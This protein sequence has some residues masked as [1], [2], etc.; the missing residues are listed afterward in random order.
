MMPNQ[1]Q[2]LRP[3]NEK[4]RSGMVGGTDLEV[5]KALGDLGGKV[6]VK[7]IARKAGL[8]VPYP[9]L[10]CNSLGKHDYMNVAGSG[11]CK[12]TAKGYQALRAKGWRSK[13]EKQGGETKPARQLIGAERF[14]SGLRQRLEASEMTKEEYQQKRAEVLVK[15]S[16][17]VKE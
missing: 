10:I 7:A 17:G 5:L 6:R 3:A 13:E 4:V 8:M 15:I 9:K 2:V 1:L 12:L 16:K 11:M 14:L